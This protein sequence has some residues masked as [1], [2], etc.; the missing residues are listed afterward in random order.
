MRRC[1][2]NGKEKPEQRLGDNIIRM[3]RQC[4]VNTIRTVSVLALQYRPIK[5]TETPVA[6][7]DSRALT[8]TCH[9]PSYM[10]W[11]ITVSIPFLYD[12]CV[13]S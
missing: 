11:R 12:L 6:N 9:V 13:A 8:E 3:S 1:F 2:S 7:T 4:L 10:E 5:I